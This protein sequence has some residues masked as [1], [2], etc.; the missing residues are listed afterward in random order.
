[1]PVHRR[2]QSGGLCLVQTFDAMRDSTAG[3]LIDDE[4]EYR[5]TREEARQ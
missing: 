3:A 2:C 1:M 5:S 4:R